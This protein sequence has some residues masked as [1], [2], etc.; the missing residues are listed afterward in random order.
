M[1]T[2]LA[3]SSLFP[4]ILIGCLLPLMAR[5]R[6]GLLFG[7][8]VPLDFTTSPIA[9]DALR[10]YVF[11]TSA[12]ALT[13]ITL[14]VL[15]YVFGHSAALPLLSFVAI[16][17]E[18]LG[19]LFFW[20]AGRRTILP[21]ATTVPLVRTAELLSHRPLGVIY[22]SLA[23]LLPPAA[24][25]LWLHTHWNQIPQRWPQHWDASGHANGW[26][27]RTP[28]GV[29]LPLVIG[30]VVLLFITGVA[31]FIA[32]APGTQTKQRRRAL[33]PLAAITWLVS[34]AFCATALLP[35]RHITSPAITA[36]AIGF[37]ILAT[38]T[39][40]LCLIHNTAAANNSPTS[41]PYDGTPDAMW[42]GGGLIY[43]NP[44]DAAILVPKRYGFGWTL[45]FA[46]PAALFF[47]A[48]LVLVVLLTTVLGIWFK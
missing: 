6:R 37:Y 32:L 12:L 22:A 45:N 29:Y 23:A 5:N 39:V 33:V 25:A 31:A 43:F 7:V 14:S 15:A 18:L 21:Y 24:V 44:S 20:Q 1:H 48:G 9:R 11:R 36:F 26:G 10:R 28:A 17:I 40:V 41:E 47:T 46:R 34:G 4:L 13:V 8:T 38:V 42:R 19:G 27:T 3:I 30:V 35:L 2:M 16:P